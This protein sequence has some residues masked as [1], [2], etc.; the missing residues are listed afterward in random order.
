MAVIPSPPPL[1]KV[2]LNSPPINKSVHEVSPEV[3]RSFDGWVTCPARP[4]KLKYLQ[5]LPGLVKK[6]E[7]RVAEGSSRRSC[8]HTRKDLWKK[9]V[10]DN[11]NT[12][13]A[14]EF[15]LYLAI[16]T[17]TSRRWEQDSAW[18]YLP[19]ELRKINHKASVGFTACALFRTNVSGQNLLEQ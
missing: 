18:F 3:R 8:I 2:R 6:K 7:G 17:L 11:V 14:K 13:W 4:E 19:Q 1:L 9:D 16:S 5:Q 10:M 15:E 12:E